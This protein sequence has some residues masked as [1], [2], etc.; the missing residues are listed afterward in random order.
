M[1]EIQDILESDAPPGIITDLQELRGCTLKNDIHEGESLQFESVEKPVRV[2]QNPISTRHHR[3]NR[4][5]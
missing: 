5:F 4:P 2:T 1:F 3:E